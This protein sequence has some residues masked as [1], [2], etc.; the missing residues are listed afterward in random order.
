MPE[1]IEL[2]GSAAAC[3]SS[4]PRARRAES[5]ISR[6]TL[7]FSTAPTSFGREHRKLSC[8][9]L[10]TNLCPVTCARW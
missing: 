3:R 5:S 9:V 10:L 2:T 1:Q 4:I 8:L 6:D 7:P